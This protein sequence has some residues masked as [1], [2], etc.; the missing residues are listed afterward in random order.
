MFGDFIQHLKK[1]HLYDESL[2]VFLSDHGEGFQEHGLLL[3]G[4]SVY[5]NMIHV[6]LIVK[7]PASYKRQGIRIEDYVQTMDLAPTILQFSQLKPP[8]YMQGKSLLRLLPG[9]TKAQKTAPVFSEVLSGKILCVIRD[10]FKYVSFGVSRREELYDLKSD[11]GETKNISAERPD[12]I[13]TFRIDRA[14]FLARTAQWEQ[15]YGLTNGEKI[16]LDENQTEQL[17]ALGYVH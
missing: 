13:K 9:Y 8:E 16:R 7:F 14:A 15:K 1:L 4:T 2:I 3:H 10:G 6:P 11:P 17:R 12:L 5:Q